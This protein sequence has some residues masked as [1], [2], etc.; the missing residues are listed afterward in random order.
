MKLG[1]LHLSD[2]HIAKPT[3]GSL[4]ITD[5]IAK[6]S[7]ELAHRSDSFIIL[8]TGDIAFSGKSS[9]YLLAKEFINRIKTKIHAETARSVDVIV[10]P[11]NHDCILKPADRIRSII[12]EQVVQDE[13][14]ATESSIVELCTKVQDDFFSFRS[15]VETL[16]PVFSDRLWNEYELEVGNATVRISSLNA[17]WMSRIP[18]PQGELVFPIEN[19]YEQL[20]VPSTLRLSLVHHPLNWYC[21]SSFHPLKKALRTHS[22]A[23]LSGHEHS[24]GS[25]EVIDPAVGS[26]LIFEGAALQPH[27]NSSDHRFSCLL[28]DL[29]GDEVTEERY[30]CSGQYP[31]KTEELNHALKKS[32]GCG[33]KNKIKSDFLER[34]SDAGGNFTGADNRSISAEDIFLYPEMEDTSAENDKRFIFADQIINSWEQDLRCIFLGDDE[35]GKSFL[36]NR[37]FLDIHNRGGLPLLIKAS[38]LGSVGDHELN[39]RIKQLASSQYAIADD[40][41]F[42]E[43][44]SK[45]ALVDDIDRLQ[46]SKNQAKLIA[47]LSEIFGSVIITAS[48]RYQ[49]NEFIDLSAAE[50]LACYKNYKLRP[51]GHIMR[52]KLIK[53]WCMLS[54]ITTKSELDKKVHDIERVLTVVLGKNLV[55]SKPI[56]LLILLQSSDL[57]QHGDLQ[58]GGFSKYYEFLIIKSLGEAGFKMDYLHEMF[59]YLSNL[60]WFY[61]SNNAKEL[62]SIKLKRFNSQFSDEFTTVEFESRFNLLVKAKVLVHSGDFYSFSYS[63]IYFLFVGK[64]LADNL[65]KDEVRDLVVSMC[66]ELHLKENASSIMFLTHYRNEP[67]VI[68]QISGVLDGCFSKYDPMEFNGDIK[69]INLLVDSTTKILINEINESDVENNQLSS[70]RLADV[71]DSNDSD[72]PDVPSSMSPEQK[73]LI[74]GFASNVN[75]MVKTSEILG[76]I[77]KSY[78]G[79]LERSRK[80]IYLEQ[81]FNGSL[82]TL[83]AV[84]QEIV[85]Q[86]DAF[87]SEL[88]RILKEKKPDLNSIDCTNSAKRLAFQVLGMIC[89]GFIARIGQVVSSEKIREDISRLVDAKNTNAFRLIGVATALVHPGHIPFDDIEK[90]ARDLS[91]NN[92]AFTILQSLVFYHLHM[93]HTTDK[94]KQRLAASVKISMNQSRAIDVVTNKG[95]MIKEI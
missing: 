72:E 2:I 20:E 6:A 46:G 40:F 37:A 17:A 35:S 26:V 75:L 44:K 88:E 59:S 9:E 19:Y 41:N 61:K 7:Y 49:L 64:Y 84:F 43:R 70:R 91:V 28:F 52:H 11:G 45:V 51:F 62:D 47:Y 74:V 30:V 56:Y 48:S 33:I 92:F 71:S 94:D 93:F 60:A 12:I 81:I 58:K 16:Q 22:N 79:S 4:L 42:A 29:E 36:L 54:E 89:T 78:Y 5:N 82:R 68:E 73:E 23:I 3:D 32:A 87:V 13:K 38:D 21:Q 55:P 76:H 1:I 69:A 63:Y 83:K 10:T 65:Y 8:I 27:G 25:E 57:Q 85:D 86:P 80:S 24:S 95:K 67:W 66:K 14:K 18:E 31:E 77:T 15:E 34:L 90:L 53:K 50:A 39:R